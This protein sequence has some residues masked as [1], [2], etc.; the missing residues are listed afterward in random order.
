MI[1]LVHVRSGDLEL[2][3]WCLMALDIVLLLPANAHQAALAQSGL[4]SARPPDIFRMMVAYCSADMTRQ[5]D[6]G[7][8]LESLTAVQV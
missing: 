2:R 3:A 6:T 8:S 7:P 4:L 5:S 1:F